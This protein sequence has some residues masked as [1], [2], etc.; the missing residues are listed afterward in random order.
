MRYPFSGPPYP[1]LEVIGDH[2]LHNLNRFRSTPGCKVLFA[3]KANAYGCGVA[4]IL[5]VLQRPEVDWVGVANVWEGWHLRQLGFQK[6]ILNLG[7]FYSENINVFFD[8]DIVPTIADMWQLEAL[9]QAAMNDGN[10]LEVHLK[11]DL[12]MGRIGLKPYD[13][14][15]IIKTLS[16]LPGLKV[17]GI[18]T[19]F[20]C[21]DEEGAEKTSKQLTAFLTL[22]DK[23]GE[24]LK[25][26]REEVLLH[27]ANS[28]AAMRFEKTRLDMVRPGILT[29]GYYQTL[30]DKEKYHNEFQVKPCLQ[31]Y[32]RPISIRQMKKG[33][34]IS[35]GSTYTVTEESISVGVLPLGYAD[36]IPRQLSNGIQFDGHDLLG[37]VTMDQVILKDIKDDTPIQIIGDKS[38]ALE[39]WAQ[40]RNTS[41]YEILTGLGPRLERV[42]V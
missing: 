13:A 9:N 41:T 17:G 32:A 37:T 14:E 5:P 27:S 21:A 26:N 4:T 3:V 39:E 23:L 19:H 18:Y 34:T 20:P 12:G 24:D 6:P 22:V 28:Y 31:M 15:Q 33:D 42:L 36:G 25:L 38:P 10:V 40:L 16:T 8:A 1:Q 11:F 7:S 35:Y 29:Y 30:A 2:L